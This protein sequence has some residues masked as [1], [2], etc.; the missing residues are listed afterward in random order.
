MLFFAF[1]IV[2]STFILIYGQMV[3]SS[4]LTYNI[5]Q[6]R[7]AVT[8]HTN[9]EIENITFDNL[10]SP[11]TTTLYVKNTGQN[12]IDLDYLDVFFDDVKIPRD[13]SNRTIIFA[14]DSQAINPIHWDSDENIIIEVYMDLVNVTHLAAVTTEHGVK[15]TRAF[16]G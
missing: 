8:V 12:K 3:E 10:T 15:D 9:L 6:E 2:I 11:D 1:L 7:L 5:Q 16:L 13:N 4:N 14:P